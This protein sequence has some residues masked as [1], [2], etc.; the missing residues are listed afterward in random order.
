M[1]GVAAYLPYHIHS[2]ATCLNLHRERTTI[3]TVITILVLFVLFVKKR[4]CVLGT[5]G[6]CS[7][8]FNKLI[9]T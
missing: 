9:V 2:K 4:K 7:A 3:Y 5:T 6:D 8:K 1:G